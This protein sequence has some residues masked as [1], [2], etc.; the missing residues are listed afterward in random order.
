MVADAM[1]GG[2]ALDHR[3]KPIDPASRFVG[4][5]LTVRAGARD[6]LA[7]AAA[8]DLIQPG[9][10]LVIAAQ[11]FAEAAVIGDNM[12]RIAQ[13]RGA[14]AIVTDGAVRDTADLLAIGLPVF[15]P[16]VTPN[17]AYG[18]GPGEVGLPIAL[19]DIA[20][21][22]G[23]LV[24]GDRDGVIV[25]PQAQLDTIAAALDEVARREAALH[26]Q[27]AGGG[28][29]TLLSPEIKAAIQYVD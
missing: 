23:D 2:G 11:G 21:A 20:I 6:N 29:Q 27:I 19:G 10:V 16:H 22:S 17:S 28:F 26:A 12:T 5:A 25:V 24:L 1:Q 7:A 15:A 13:M 4:S 18:S 9:D 8:L 3:I 14:A